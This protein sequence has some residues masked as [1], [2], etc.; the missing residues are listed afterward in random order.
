M[1]EHRWLLP[2]VLPEK[3]TEL[4]LIYLVDENGGGTAPTGQCNRTSEALIGSDSRNKA[5][6]VYGSLDSTELH[7]D[8][9]L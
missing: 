6:H 7:M 2:Y 9:H 3:F 4:H 5:V 1:K 8:S